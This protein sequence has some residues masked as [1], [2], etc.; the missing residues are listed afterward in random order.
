MEGTS[1]G[2]PILPP[3]CSL[4]S[5]GSSSGC[6]GSCPARFCT[7][8]RTTISQPHMVTCPCVSP[9]SE[10]YFYCISFVFTLLQ[11]TSTALHTTT[12]LL[13]LSFFFNLAHYAGEDS[14]H[15][16]SIHL[17]FSNLNKPCFAGRHDMRQNEHW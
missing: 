14:R 4:T 16:L 6:S 13:T 7:A 15:S 2:H 9:P 3:V 10:H 8:S 12:A 17:L 1:G 5:P 11:L